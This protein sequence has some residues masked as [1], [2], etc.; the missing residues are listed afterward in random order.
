[1]RS[2]VDTY[3]ISWWNPCIKSWY[4]ELLNLFWLFFSNLQYVHCSIPQNSSPKIDIIEPKYFPYLSFKAINMISCKPLT[5]TPITLFVFAPRIIIISVY[6]YMNL[7]V[8][9]GQNVPTNNG[10][11]DKFFDIAPKKVLYVN[12]SIF[13]WDE[14]IGRY[15]HILI[16]K[17]WLDIIFDHFRR[18]DFIYDKK[19]L[20]FIKNNLFFLFFLLIFLLNSI[21][22]CICLLLLIL[23][24]YRDCHSSYNRTANKNLYALISICAYFICV[25]CFVS[26][27]CVVFAEIH[28]RTHL[29]KHIMSVYICLNNT[30][31]TCQYFWHYVCACLFFYYEVVSHL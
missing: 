11:I 10:S 29:Q 14:T 3:L 20:I 2:C 28:K 9:Q 31:S 12:L 6:P 30:W 7:F 21:F 25:F 15:L 24:S 16:Q 4:L 13:L 22:E 19:L 23:I 27:V 5:F 17:Q 8:H 18:F 1:M 26:F